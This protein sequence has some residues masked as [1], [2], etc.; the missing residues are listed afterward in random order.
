MLN[1]P[2]IT[3]SSHNNE[4]V[5]NSRICENLFYSARHK[6]FQLTIS[7]QF[8]QSIHWISVCLVSYDL[9]V[10]P[11]NQFVQQCTQ[12]ISSNLK[13][14]S[15]L[16]SLRTFFIFYRFQTHLTLI[17]ADIL[18]LMS[19]DRGKNK[20]AYKHSRYKSESRTQETS[21]C[22]IFDRK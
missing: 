21:K 1:Y 4:F 17:I 9:Q 16:S 7:N 2:F 10:K 13:Y 15:I 12:K 19:E 8:L 11:F 3:T 14:L 5:A 20:H 6:P 18:F 22:I